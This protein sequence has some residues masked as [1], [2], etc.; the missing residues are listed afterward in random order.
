[1]VDR[2]QTPLE[3]AEKIAETFNVK[4]HFID[5]F[6]DVDEDKDGFFYARLKAKKF[7]DKA[8]F[9]ALCALARD[10]GGEGYLQGAKAWRVPGPL[11]K[12]ARS[13]TSPSEGVKVA[14]KYPIP[15]LSPTSQPTAPSEPEE[16][17]IDSEL[18]EELKES[19][20]KFGP[21]SPVVLDVHGNV[22]E[23]HHRKRADSKW[24]QITYSQIQSEEDRVLYA[25]AFNWHRREKTETWKRKQLA[26]L[27][28]QGYS[29]D[30]I[31]ERTGLNKRTVYRYLPSELKGSEPPQFAGTHV[32]SDSLSLNLKP[33]DMSEGQIREFLDSPKVKEVAHAMQTETAVGPSGEIHETESDKGPIETSEKTQ[34]GPTEEPVQIGEFDCTECHQ[35]FLIDHVSTR[36]HKVRLVKEG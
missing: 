30:Q 18:V 22:V 21:L 27:A 1:M 20:R 29:I 6:F 12:S 34:T 28:K 23:G 33:Q 14:E 36:I 16:S 11:Y 26:W 35:H 32:T 13:P 7:L 24:P 25:I 4:L 8:Q 5:E 19:K 9:R 15:L 2:L 3:F 31:V 10:L 17:E